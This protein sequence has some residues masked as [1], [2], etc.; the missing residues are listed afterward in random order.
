MFMC[1]NAFVREPTWVRR[2]KIRTEMSFNWSDFQE[3]GLCALSRGG[4]HQFCVITCALT[5]LLRSPIHQNIKEKMVTSNE[6]D[7]VHIFRTLKNTARVYKNKV[8]K[9]VV[10]IE[11]RPGGAKFEDIRELVSGAR[12]RLVYVNG[13]P[14][15]GI[16]SAGIAVGL[17]KGSVNQI[18]FFVSVADRLI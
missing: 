16:W 14:D 6:T 7:T 15:Y 17:I 3:H 9:E 8:S 18:S 11:R 5:F 13:D 2:S 4:L 1:V 12:G 10:A